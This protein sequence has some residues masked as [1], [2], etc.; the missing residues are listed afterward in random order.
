MTGTRRHSPD[1]SNVSDRP[2]LLPSRW[3]RIR[4]CTACSISWR[5]TGRTCE[6][7]HS[8][9]VALRLIS[10]ITLNS[11]LQHSEA[12]RGDSQRR[13]E[14]A[15]RLGWEGLIAKRADAPYASGRSKDWLKLKCVWEQEFVIGGYTDP[16]GSR[17]DFGALLV[18]YHE[19]GSLRYAGKVGTG[20]TKATL[21]DL[22][23]RL[24][25][26]VTSKSPFRDVRPL[27]RGH[28]LDAS[29][30][31]RP[32][33]IRRVDERCSA[34]AAALPRT[35]RRQGS[36]RRRPGAAA[37]TWSRVLAGSRCLRGFGQRPD[38]NAAGQSLTQAYWTRNGAERD[39]GNARLAGE[40]GRAG[41]ACGTFKWTDRSVSRVL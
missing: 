10:T 16:T 6:N 13:F 22:G 19:Q 34:Q 1:S 24:R 36:R 23:L 32:D 5:S 28:T 38:D 14:E 29:E 33:R 11:A 30:A 4:S 15:C 37:M 26:L 39:D 9:T 20:F 17:T 7:S 27:P 8:S 3:R 25:K 35:S 40:S 41:R 21:N 18:G 31:R 12:R 2:H